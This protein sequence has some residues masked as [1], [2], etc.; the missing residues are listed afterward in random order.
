MFFKMVNQEG[1]GSEV[2]YNA[3]HITKIEVLY[4][5]L[6]DD[7]YV[8]LSSLERGQI[9]PELVRVYCVTIAGEKE[10]LQLFASNGG[11]VFDYIADIYKNAIG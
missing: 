3:D 4:G 6:K 9:S 1:L 2:L 11:P 7:K 5:E 8:H 10:P